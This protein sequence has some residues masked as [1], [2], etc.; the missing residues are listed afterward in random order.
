M[1]YPLNQPGGTSQCWLRTHYLSHWV[2]QSIKILGLWAWAGELSRGKKRVIACRVWTSD[3]WITRS[4]PY[5]LNHLVRTIVCVDSEL[6]IWV[7]ESPNLQKYWAS[8]PEP[9][10]WVVTKKGDCLP[11]INSSLAVS[12]KLVNTASLANF[13]THW[14]IFMTICLEKSRNLEKFQS[15]S[16]QQVSKYS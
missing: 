1:P 2:T 13:G 11:N 9:A 14:E 10:S 16:Q 8:E 15:R 6:I 5:P 4:M 12:S 7:I 3:L